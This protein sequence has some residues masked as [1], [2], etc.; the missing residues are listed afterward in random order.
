[1]RHALPVIIEDVENPKQRLQHDHHGRKK[2]RLQML[3]LLASGQAQTRRDVAKLL[4]VYRHTIGHWPARYATGG[5][6]SLP[7][8]YVPLGKPVSL[9]PDV[10]SGLEQALR[11]PASFASY[12]A[13]TVAQATLPT[14]R[15]VSHARHDRPHPI[16]R[17]AQ[18]AAAQSHRNT[19]RR[20]RT[21]RR[22]VRSG[23]KASSRRSIPARYTCLARTNAVWGGRP[24]VAAGSPRTGFSPW[25]QSNR[26]LNGSMSMGQ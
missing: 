15:Q 26:S 4:G 11:Q 10:L 5:V 20:L 16:Q 12:E 1:M 9:P 8:L 18:G 23:S 6:E 19:L 2:P 7:D 14:G 22:P 13:V 25:E 21:S 3:A 17:Q 24:C